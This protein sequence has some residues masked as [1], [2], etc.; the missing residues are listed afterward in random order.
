YSELD[1]RSNRP[2]AT[3]IAENLATMAWYAERGIPVEVNEAHHWSLREASD[4][5]AVAMAYLAAAFAK[6]Q[7]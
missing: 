2:L 6:Q 4:T 7:G 3:A 1:G 5:I